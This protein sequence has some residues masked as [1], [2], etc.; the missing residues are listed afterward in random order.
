MKKSRRKSRKSRR[1]RKSRKP[2]EKIISQS[3]S[4]SKN[5]L[6]SFFDNIY[7]VNLHDKIERFSTMAKQFKK[8]KIKF[9]RFDA[10]DGRCKD[11]ECKIKKKE[12]EKKYKVKISSKLVIP[13]ASLTIGTLLMLRTMVKNRWK[14][15]L[16]CEDDINLEKDFSQKFENGIRQ[17]EHAKK[18]KWD[19]LYLGSGGA[20]GFQDISE[21]RTSKIKHLTSWAISDDSLEF[22][23]KNKDDLRMPC[24][25]DQCVKIT[26]NITQSFGVGGTW[27]YAYSLKGAK[28]LI[29]LMDNKISN[30]IDQVLMKAQDN[31]DMTAYCYDPPIVYH[32]GGAVRPDTTIPWG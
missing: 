20:T 1:S 6:N 14:Y 10:V 4:G 13:A 19:V 5:F 8:Q 7:I 24:Y 21:K 11:E 2:T 23:V 27:C 22:Y 26:E 17:L 3:Y 31:G 9:E 32:E 18:M 28:K 16:I 30:H 15:L 29:K 12:L 25:D